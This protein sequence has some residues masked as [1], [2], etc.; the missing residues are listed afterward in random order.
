MTLLELPEKDIYSD[1]DLKLQ[2]HQMEMI[3]RIKQSMF[4][5]M[6]A[7]GFLFSTPAHSALITYSFDGQISSV[8]HSPMGIVSEAAFLGHFAVNTPASVSM[9]ID[10]DGNPDHLVMTALN[11]TMGADSF[12][13]TSIVGQDV[14]LTNDEQVLLSS[15]DRMEIFTLEVMG[16]YP[17]GLTTESM[18]FFFSEP[19]PGVFS[20]STPS[21][22]EMV[23]LATYSFQTPLAVR[24]GFEDVDGNYNGAILVSPMGAAINVDVEDS[25]PPEVPLP[26]ALPLMLSG[27]FGIGAL[28]LKSTVFP[29]LSTMSPASYRGPSSGNKSE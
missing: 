20:S 28:S 2:V 26:A 14:L 3:K 22:L 5:T 23:S 29:V 16:S 6:L 25:R 24:I 15:Y 27:L 17:L 1:S 9:T 19:S 13:M 11:V 4:A 7:T 21:V 8:G 12:S 18:L 10:Y